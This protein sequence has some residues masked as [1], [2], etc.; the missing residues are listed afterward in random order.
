[1][2][3]EPNIMSPIEFHQKIEDMVYDSNDQI[4]YIDAIIEFCIR[5]NMEIESVSSLMSEPLKAR[6]QNDAENLQL[7]KKSGARLPI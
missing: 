5:N 1:M 4:S 6:L 2:K 7:V 3:P